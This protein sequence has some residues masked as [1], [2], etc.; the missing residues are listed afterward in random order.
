M[1][2]A[3]IYQ[4]QLANITLLHGLHPRALYKFFHFQFDH[5]QNKKLGLHQKRNLQV[6]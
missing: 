1:K 3:G 4:K 5:K 6:V 2:L